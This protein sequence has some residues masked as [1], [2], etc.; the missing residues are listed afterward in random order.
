MPDARDSVQAAESDV[1]PPS[2]A[3]PARKSGHRVL[4]AVLLV[5]ATIVGIAGV[6]AVWVNRQ[7]LNTSNWASTSGKILDDKQV[8]D[9]VSAYIV[10]ELF[11][12]VDVPGALQKT[13]PAQLQPLAGPAAAGLQQLAGQLAPKV[14][15]SPAAQAAWVQANVAAHTQ[16]LKVLNGGGPV[17]STQSGV[18]TL[19]LHALASQ[20]AATLG[21]S[22]QVAAAQS[23]LQGSTGAS[24]RA[25]AQQKL[26]ITLPPASGQLVIL[27][28][29]QLGTAQDVANGV[30][31]LAIVLPAVAILLFALAV[32][33]AR[34]RR[35]RTLRTSGWCL[36]L[37]GVVL[38]LIRR[39]GGDA[40]VDGLVKVS[41]NKPAVHD[42]WN[43]ATSLLYAL[44]VA[45]IVYGL[46]LV[47]AAWLAGPTRPATTIRK[48][49]APSMRD[50]PAV[51]Y[52]VVGGVLALVVLWG[53]TPA[54]RNVWWILVFVVLL[55]LGV[56]ML[57]RETA[58]E[59]PD[60]EP[61]QALRD[62]REQRAQ[63][64]AREAAAAQ[65]AASG[66]S[67]GGPAVATASPAPGSGRVD[68]LERLAALRDRGAIT[69]DEYQAEKTLVINNHT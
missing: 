19:N 14:L 58:V 41:S 15:A 51:A 42:V 45:L 34:G 3:A 36:V 24:V 69:D 67:A 54:F 61:G 49:L 8:Q 2:G 47:A 57:R 56:T 21:V 25:A 63:S 50:H 17:V 20:L 60:I 18:V 53:P 30:K 64:G 12:N 26:G 7:A 68:S 22:G 16:L 44:A 13:L 38:L 32:Y 43:I 39:V 59:F 35:R 55:A 40:V 29:D 37:I 5:L 46:V 62:F 65:L 6:F 27:R 48:A 23:K 11:S 33:L 10:R 4:V 66:M 1:P 28:S 9:A 52:L 31:G